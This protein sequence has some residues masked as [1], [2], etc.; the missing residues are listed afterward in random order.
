MSTTQSE[1]Y[2]SIAT[3]A[4][5]IVGWAWMVSVLSQALVQPAIV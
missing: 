1:R 2:A 4:G 5:T 3:I